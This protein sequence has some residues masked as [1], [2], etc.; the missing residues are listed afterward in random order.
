M[1]FSA[2]TAPMPGIYSETIYYNY[3]SSFGGV[4]QSAGSTAALVVRNDGSFERPMT[5]LVSPMQFHCSFTNVDPMSCLADCCP[6]QLSTPVMY[7][8]RAGRTM[9]VGGTCQF[10]TM[11]SGSYV[12]TITDVEGYLSR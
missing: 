7:F 2:C 8:D 9:W 1:A 4:A 11:P 6:G 12:A 5:A 10:T 3:V